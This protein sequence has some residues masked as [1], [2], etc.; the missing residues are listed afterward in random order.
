MVELYKKGYS[1]YLMLRMGSRTLAPPLPLQH[2]GIVEIALPKH[3]AQRPLVESGSHCAIPYSVCALVTLTALAANFFSP[4]ELS[5]AFPS[6]L[7]NTFDSNW[8]KWS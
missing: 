2:V 8:L 7:F 6:K 4:M 3:T 1:W 5:K